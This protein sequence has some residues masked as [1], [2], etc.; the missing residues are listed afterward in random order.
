MDA[1]N[2]EP[3]ALRD[4]DNLALGYVSLKINK[5]ED[6]VRY[7]NKVRLNGALSS[8][9]LLGIGWAW[10]SQSMHDKSLIPW[11][12]L[13]NYSALDPSVQ[14][15]LI[16]IPYTLEQIGRPDL[17]LDHY[18]NA[19]N[20]YTQQSEALNNIITSIRNGDFME[21]LLATSSGREPYPGKSRSNSQQ[22]LSFPYFYELFSSNEFQQQLRE[23]EDLIYLQHITSRW[24]D[25]LPAINLMLVER[26]KNY[27]RKLREI[28]I[29]KRSAI[30]QPLINKRNKLDR[31]LKNI[32]ALALASNNDK[33]KLESLSLINT[34]LNKISG[35]YNVSDLKE[36]HDR[37]YGLLYWNINTDYKPRLWQAKKSLKEL[38]KNIE[39]NTHLQQSLSASID[40][41]PK[42][43]AGYSKRISSHHNKIEKL[44][45][46][47]NNALTE[48]KSII[49]SLAITS[50]HNHASRINSYQLRARYSLAR[51]YDKQSKSSGISNE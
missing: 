26:K 2:Q 1:H 30:I 21:S 16:A 18:K 34:K 20:S 17:S 36:K 19:I 39:T 3:S 35:K 41:A 51:I 40:N 24:N 10:S 22:A 28:E 23:L 37:L 6:A 12:E 43:F 47:I 8:R 44:N 46:Q 7:F 38:D 50:A 4:K 49:N 25:S 48:Q 15:S 11:L 27:Q 32:D 29:K 45:I 5:P 42:S 14:E 9:A 33:I 31:I 13:K